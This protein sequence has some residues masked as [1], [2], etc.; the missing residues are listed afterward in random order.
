MENLPQLSTG[1]SDDSDSSL[2]DGR[3]MDMK[4]SILT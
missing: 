2:L 1:V 3:W 4:L